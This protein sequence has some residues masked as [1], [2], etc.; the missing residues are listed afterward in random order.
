MFTGYC[1]CVWRRTFSLC[2]SVW[3]VAG[4]VIGRCCL[5]FLWADALLI[6]AYQVFLGNPNNTCGLCA[7]VG[8]MMERG[9]LIRIRRKEGS[10]FRT[11]T[12][13]WIS[14]WKFKSQYNSSVSRY[15]C[16]VWQRTFSFA[17]VV[18]KGRRSCDNCTLSCGRF[19]HY[20]CKDCTA[21]CASAV[22]QMVKFMTKSNF[23]FSDRT[24]WH[25]GIN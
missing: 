4:V 12:H 3:Q 6:G 19:F 7:A 24:S 1:A 9:T 13:F 5:G 18:K 11:I 20:T 16:K 10:A 23:Y 15:G 21:K 25:N 2:Q 14:F 8:L 17:H 22:S